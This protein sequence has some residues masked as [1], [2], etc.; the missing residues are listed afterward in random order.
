MKA[1]SG[2]A[3]VAVGILSLAACSE[4]APQR[5]VSSNPPGTEVTRAY[6]RVAGTN[7]SGAYPTQSDGTPNNPSGTSATRA[8]D[9]AMGTNVSGAYPGQADGTPNNPPGTA[10]SRAVRRATN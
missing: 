2:L 6:D 10:A 7:V 3:V 1:K 8:Y 4:P 9:R 5:S